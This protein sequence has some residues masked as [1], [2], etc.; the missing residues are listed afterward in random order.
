V[1]VVS[2]DSF[3]FL[4]CTPHTLRS[5]SQSPS[6]VYGLPKPS[7]PIVLPTYDKENRW[8]T[9]SDDPLGS[10]RGMP[11]GRTNG[12]MIKVDKTKRFLFHDMTNFMDKVGDACS[13][14]SN[15]LTFMGIVL[16][17]LAP[18]TLRN[19]LYICIGSNGPN[20]ID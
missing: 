4:P 1:W 14:F 11:G 13:P 18:F 19:Q 17:R 10:I 20:H 7:D 16:S 9:N 3:H 15:E 6:G 8:A 5:S 12:D 2:K